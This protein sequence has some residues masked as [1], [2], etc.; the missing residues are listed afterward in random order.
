MLLVLLFMTPWQE[1]KTEWMDHVMLPL[2]L[3]NG[4]VDVVSYVR[5]YAV[6][7]ATLALASSFN[8]MTLGGTGER[9]VMVTALMI[10]VLV[11]GH[12]LNFVL[13]GMGVLVHGIR[14]NTL[15]FA[16][17][18]GMTWSGIPYA[19]FT[20]LRSKTDEPLMTGEEHGSD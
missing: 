10:V 3:V 17:H 20:L 16:S 12:A 14:L 1:L 18:L 2:S 9:S 5:L 15:E 6:G 19:P 8:E 4:F 13:A 7:M 11:L